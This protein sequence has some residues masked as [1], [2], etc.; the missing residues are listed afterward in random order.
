MIPLGMG[1]RG[2]AR[3][4][5]HVESQNFCT[6]K[7]HKSADP[8]FMSESAQPECLTASASNHPVDQ[9]SNHRRNDYCRTVLQEP[10]SLPKSSSN[11]TA[12]YGRWIRQAGVG[13]RRNDLPVQGNLALYPTAVNYGHRQTRGLIR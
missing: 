5:L 2:E 6:T 9:C 12:M 13:G 7:V 3:P 4:A 1:T 8:P 11:D 10:S